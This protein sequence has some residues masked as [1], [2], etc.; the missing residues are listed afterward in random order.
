MAVIINSARIRIRAVKILSGTT[1]PETA[2]PAGRILLQN[3]NGYVSPESG[4]GGSAI[5]QG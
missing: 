3:G 1:A 5:A 4:T 2:P